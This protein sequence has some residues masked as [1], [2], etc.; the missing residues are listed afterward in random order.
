MK[1]LIMLLVAVLLLAL[2]SC[3]TEPEVD[4]GVNPFIIY[5]GDVSNINY[6][7]PAGYSGATLPDGFTLSGK[8]MCLEILLGVFKRG[9]W[10]NTYFVVA[11]IYGAYIWKENNWVYWRDTGCP[12]SEINNH[13]PCCGIIRDCI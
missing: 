4:N 7:I 3:F 9:E 13:H 8:E 2:G 12:Y 10:G 5:Y 6:K 1:K 11:D